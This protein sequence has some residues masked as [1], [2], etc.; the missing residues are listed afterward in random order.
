L[1][2][3][4][5]EKKGDQ[6]QHG[7]GPKPSRPARGDVNDEQQ[8]SSEPQSARQA[9]QNRQAVDGEGDPQPAA[10]FRVSS[11]VT[12]HGGEDEQLHNGINHPVMEESTAAQVKRRVGIRAQ[13]VT[14]TYQTDHEASDEGDGTSRGGNKSNSP[15]SY[16]VIRTGQGGNYQK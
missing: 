11:V 6:G 5:S 4:R 9:E 3:L 14:V 7:N 10:V 12:K 15:D 16:A 1:Y 2:G 13:L 8:Q